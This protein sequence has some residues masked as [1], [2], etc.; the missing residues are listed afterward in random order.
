[1]LSKTIVVNI[2]K[3]K[4]DKYI[5]RPS[6]LGNPFVI[7]KD[8]TR[9]EVIEKYAVWLDNKIFRG[10]ISDEYLAEYSGKRLGCFCAPQPCHGDVI[11]DRS[12]KAA[13]R[14]MKDT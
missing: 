14:L 3:G 12:D 9:E 4:Y 8:G 6:P 1:M 11:K 5:G 10:E 7:G 13:K 2:Y